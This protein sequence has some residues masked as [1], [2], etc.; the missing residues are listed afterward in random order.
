[1]LESLGAI[2]TNP[3][4]TTEEEMYANIDKLISDAQGKIIIGTF[5]SQIKR[6][7]HIIE[8]AEKIGKKV[9]LDGYSMKMNIER[10]TI[11]C[12][13]IDIIEDILCDFFPK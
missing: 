10:S 8:Y 12:G 5:S 1:M 4:R 2:V 3:T 11:S 6:I 9:A 7:G 13:S